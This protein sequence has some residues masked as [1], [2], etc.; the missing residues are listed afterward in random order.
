VIRF[1]FSDRTMEEVTANNPKWLL[2]PGL[3]KSK[4]L[5]N[6]HRIAGRLVT[7]LWVRAVTLFSMSKL[8]IEE[9]ELIELGQLFR[10]IQ[11]LLR[12]TL[13]RRFFEGLVAAR[14]SGPGG[15]PCGL[16]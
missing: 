8:F 10:I 4:V 1:A 11:N 12:G 3:V 7:F 14:E 15:G 13:L 16:R 5:F 6:F 9:V 2:P